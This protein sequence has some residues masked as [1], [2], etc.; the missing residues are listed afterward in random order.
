[1][2]LAEWLLL[3]ILVKVIWTGSLLA[4][5]WT[6]SPTWSVDRP[7]VWHEDWDV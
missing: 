5:I 1:M 4:Y 3:A 7:D 6:L 2:R